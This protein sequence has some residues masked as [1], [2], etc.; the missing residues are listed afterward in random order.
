[1]KCVINLSLL[2]SEIVFGE[3]LSVAEFI[4]L[5]DA[6]KAEFAKGANS[7]ISASNIHESLSILVTALR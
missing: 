5:F 1:M 3:D 2:L 4:S 7:A 6:K